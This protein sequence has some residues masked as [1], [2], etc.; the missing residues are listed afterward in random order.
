MSQE[1]LF[2]EARREI[3]ALDD[4]SDILYIPAWIT[5]ERA[6]RV[7]TRL[8]TEVDWQQPTISIAGQQHKIPRLQ[9]WYGDSG[10]VMEYSG[11]SFTPVAWTALLA[12]MKSGVER[13]AG[14]G[15]NSVLVNL[16]RDGQDSVSWHADNE[17]ELGKNPVIASVSLGA[18][19]IFSLKPRSRS[20]D[21][22]FK[23][24]GKGDKQNPSQTI[25]LPLHSGDLI[26]MRGET[27]QRWQ[28]AVL[29]VKSSV[30]PRI[31]LT[32]RQIVHKRSGL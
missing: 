23:Q 22:D 27:Q 18:T 6:S 7:F 4:A 16:Y 17:K 29:K 25:K 21:V 14:Q 30:G 5:E 2:N 32:F 8:N 3:I 31:N 26:V 28:H 13:E 19:R 11:Q 9:A 24:T 1:S 12:N 15:F 20:S 10:A